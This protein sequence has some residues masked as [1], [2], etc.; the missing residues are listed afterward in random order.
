MHFFVRSIL[1]ALALASPLAQAAGS[2]ACQPGQPIRDSG[3]VKI[4]GIA[5]WISIDGADC[6][7]P[8]L[9]LVH[10]G[11]GNPIS[12]YENDP[13]ASWTRDYVVVHWDQRAS[14]LTWGR[15]APAEDTPLTLAQMRDDGIALSRHLLARLG[16]RKLVLLGSSW[17]SILGG[18]M[19]AH[20][21][22]L[23]CAWMPVAQVV[24]GADTMRAS[25]EIILARARAAGDQATV[26]RITALGAPPWT[27]PRNFGILRRAV[28]KYEA[29][30]SDPATAAWMAWKAARNTPKARADYEAAEDYSYIQFIGMKGDGIASTVDMAAQAARFGMPVY[31]VHGDQDLLAPKEIA[32]RYFAR[33][34]APRK[35][36]VVVERAGHDPNI[37]LIDAQARLLASA[38]GGRC[39]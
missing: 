36:L 38:L 9:L 30:V 7:K 3:Y 17:G 31:M 19:A 6:A 26:E 16:K 15:N 27:N 21:P 37:P 22:E 32:Q 1:A 34:A 10:G 5:Q 11:P 2:T 33:I 20:G 28:R 8:A 13:Y 12:I 39:E 35:Q 25:R 23:Y 24:N 18:H 29:L 4:G 14:G